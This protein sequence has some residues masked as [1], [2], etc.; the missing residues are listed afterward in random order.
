[1]I[2]ILINENKRKTLLKK[3]DSENKLI[4][5]IAS[6]RRKIFYLDQISHRALARCTSV[7]L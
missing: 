6:L 2:V 3:M 4:I 5:F 1:M 7:L